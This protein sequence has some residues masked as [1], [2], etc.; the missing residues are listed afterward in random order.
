MIFSASLHDHL[1]LHNL[2]AALHGCSLHALSA[3]APHDLFLPLHQG[4]EI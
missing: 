2:S 3:A 1:S 4:G